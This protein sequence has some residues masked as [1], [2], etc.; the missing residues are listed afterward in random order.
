MGQW[1]VVKTTL[2]NRAKLLLELIL[3]IGILL[4]RGTVVKSIKE[5]F[6]IPS[7]TPCIL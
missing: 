5:P 1:R 6:D 3:Q 2:A 7:N 4:K